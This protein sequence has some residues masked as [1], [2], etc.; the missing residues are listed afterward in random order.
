MMGLSATY[1]EKEIFRIQKQTSN[2]S[3]AQF[4]DLIVEKS[5]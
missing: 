2:D 4:I 5:T 1:K 3:N